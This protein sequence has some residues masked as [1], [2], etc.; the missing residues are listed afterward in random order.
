M[1]GFGHGDERRD[2]DAAGHQQRA[3]R[4]PAQG[5]IVSRRGDRQDVAFPHN[6]MKATGAAARG[7]LTLDSDDVA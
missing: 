7:V 1:Q 6:I 3:D 4:I 5:K 2:A